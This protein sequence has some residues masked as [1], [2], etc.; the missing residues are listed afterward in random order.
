[1]NSFEFKSQKNF[2]RALG[3]NG[4]DVDPSDSLLEEENERLALKHSERAE[5]DI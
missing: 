4:S 1:L 2:N 5:N 3:K